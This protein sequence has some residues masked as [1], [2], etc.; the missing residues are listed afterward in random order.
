MALLAHPYKGTELRELCDDVSS[1]CKQALGG[2]LR[3]SG[4]VRWFNASRGFGFIG[5][6]E[7]ADVFAHA[8]ALRIE[9]R[10]SL[11]PGERVDFEVSETKGRLY[12]VN[13]RLASR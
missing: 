9:G 3:C 5:R 1:G 13:V 10:S 4:I 7:D 6:G 12:A 2:T 11:S 8:S